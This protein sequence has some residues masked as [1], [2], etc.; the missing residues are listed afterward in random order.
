MILRK[1]DSFGLRE[2]SKKIGIIFFVKVLYDHNKMMKLQDGPELT[3][4]LNEFLY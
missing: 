3:Q 4:L 1:F 2:G